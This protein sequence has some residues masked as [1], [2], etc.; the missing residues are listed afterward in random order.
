MAHIVLRLC[1]HSYVHRVGRT[2]RAGR[3]GTAITFVQI[4]EY[5]AILFLC[6]ID[7]SCLQYTKADRMSMRPLAEVARRSGAN[8]PDWMFT[9]RKPKSGAV[10]FRL[11][12]LFRWQR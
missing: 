2:G 8:V 6:L 4:Y 12:L 10:E 3:R 9:M 11:L 1:G 5:F 7:Q